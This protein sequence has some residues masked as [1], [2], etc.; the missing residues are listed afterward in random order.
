MAVAALSDCLPAPAE[1][2]PI[3]EALNEF[4]FGIMVGRN[5]RRCRFATMMEYRPTK[6]LRGDDG[7]GS[8]QGMHAPAANLRQHTK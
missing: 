2:L 8:R 7:I 3:A 6:T 4:D 5:R 1:P